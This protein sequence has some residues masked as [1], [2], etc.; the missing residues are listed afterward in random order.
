MGALPLHRLDTP[1][2]AAWWV[3]HTRPRCEKKMD[4]WLAARGMD[5]YLP[6]RPKVRIY[7]G[8]KVT[9][10]HPLFAGYAFG[11]FSLRQRAFVLDSGHAAGVLDVTDQARF[12]GEL[13]AVRKALETGTPLEECPYIS[14]GH[15]ARITAGPCRGLEGRVE[16]VAGKARF[17]LSVELLQRSVAMEVESS[18]LELAA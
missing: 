8:K 13:A 18:L 17:I 11:S 3:I 5:H 1:D 2:A 9:F 10:E 6:V 16:R 4:Q 7:P 15:R 14:V 12:L